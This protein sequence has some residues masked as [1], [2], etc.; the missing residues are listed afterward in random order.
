MVLGNCYIVLCLHRQFL[1]R[2]YILCLLHFLIPIK[3]TAASF[4]T[5]HLVTHYFTYLFIDPLI[6]SF[7]SIQ[8]NQQLTYDSLL[9]PIYPCSLRLHRTSSSCGHTPHSHTGTRPLG[10]EV[11]GALSSGCSAP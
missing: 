9:H 4:L 7:K 10:S 5:V 3:M 6:I 8:K 1:F 2:G 11:S